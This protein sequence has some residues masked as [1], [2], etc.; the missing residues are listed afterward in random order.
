MIYSIFNSLYD[1]SSQLVKYYGTSLGPGAYL[2]GL[3][4]YAAFSISIFALYYTFR[5]IGLYKMAKNC[6]YSKPGLAIVPFVGL[7]V[8]YQL[9]PRSKYLKKQTALMVLAIVFGGLVLVF[10]CL[11]DAFYGIPAI[12]DLIDLNNHMISTGQLFMVPASVF[13]LDRTFPSLLSGY[14]A[15]VNLAYAVFALFVYN[16]LFMSY[17]LKSTKLTIFSAFVYYF[18]GTFLLAGIFIFAK[19]NKP[20]INYDAYIEARRQFAQNSAYGRNPYGP[21]GGPY[22]NG[23]GYGGYNQPNPNGYNEQKRDIDPFEEFSS[24]SN[25]NN[26]N[27]G[28]SDDFFN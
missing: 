13:S 24:K 18:T 4:V 16:R 2:I 7:Y 15:I 12:F 17:T 20:R 10:N 3:I 25:S 22:N 8:C 19:R 21:Y 27:S 9:A 28:D 26:G 23:Q 5:S 11:L 1:F 14:L 6:G